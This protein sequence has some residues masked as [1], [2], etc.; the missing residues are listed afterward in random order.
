MDLFNRI[1]CEANKKQCCSQMHHL[2]S[3]R[4]KPCALKYD[5]I[6][7]QHCLCFVQI[8][9]REKEIQRVM[10]ILAR[11]RK[12]N[13]VLLGE[14]GVGKTAIA[15]GIARAI[16]T[17]FAPNGS[18]IPEFLKGMRVMQLDVALLMAGAKERGELEKRVTSLV[19]E[20]STSPDVIL[21]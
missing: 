15:E 14:A 10:Q 20:V 5:G 3:I 6:Q 9:G 16:V 17:G 2:Q 18:P 21:M 12:N 7:I 19:E 4:G 1:I 13:P 11:R 8:I